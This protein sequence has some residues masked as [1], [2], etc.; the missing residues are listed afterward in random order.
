MLERRGLT[1]KQ[2][3]NAYELFRELHGLG[4]LGGAF[5]ALAEELEQEE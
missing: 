3:R 2:A 4:M 5:S 1:A